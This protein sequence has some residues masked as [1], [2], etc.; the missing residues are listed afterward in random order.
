MYP[1]LWQLHSNVWLQ[2]LHA[3]GVI[4][5]PFSTY[6]WCLT[7]SLRV[8]LTLIFFLEIGRCLRDHTPLL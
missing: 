7:C 2:F 5:V 1:V 4:Y 8:A 3:I 6:W